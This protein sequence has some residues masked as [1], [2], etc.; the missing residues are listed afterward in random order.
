MGGLPN[1]HIRNRW[2]GHDGLPGWKKD[3][4]GALTFHFGHG[5]GSNYWDILQ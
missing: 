1:G 3:P 2:P 4:Q 5:I